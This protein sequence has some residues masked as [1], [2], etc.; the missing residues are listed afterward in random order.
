MAKLVN[1]QGQKF[2]R[3][4]V[5]EWAGSDKHQKILWR[6][7]CECGN[8][9]VVP[10]AHLRSGHTSSC[11]CSRNES[12]SKLFFIDL[13]GQRFGRLTVISRAENRGKQTRWHCVCDDGNEAV[14][15]AHSLRSGGTQSCG[16]LQSEIATA[17]RTKH[18][19][20]PSSARGRKASP[21]YTAWWNMLKRCYN[22]NNP[23]YKDWGGR[24]ITV[25]DRWRFGEDGLTGFECF[26]IDM[27]PKPSRK[28][29]IHRKDNDKG[30][31]PD[32]CIW[33]TEDVQQNEK[34]SNRFVT[35][36]GRRLTVVQWARESKHRASTL[37]DRLNGGWPPEA[38][39]IPVGASSLSIYEMSY[40]EAM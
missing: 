35:I 4:T 14:V 8:E 17:L 24:G 28:H 3:L 33:A 18:G 12:T 31:N 20:A 30:Y 9:R 27:G 37:H 39:L 38:L 10:T 26:L 1:L 23:R 21:E 32:N 19:H 36:D 29:S 5:K 15:D 11:G 2:G 7:V 6:C 22:S 25:C 40:T 34:R 16:C 13:T